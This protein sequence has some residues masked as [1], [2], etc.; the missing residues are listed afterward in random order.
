MRGA[1]RVKFSWRVM[2]VLTVMVAA[3]FSYGAY[4]VQG[5]PTEEHEVTT[6]CSYEQNIRCNY[7]AYLKP[8]ILYGDA[9]GEGETIYIKLAERIDVTF[10]YTFSCSVEGS[11]STDYE[12]R[13]FLEEPSETGWRK[14]ID[15]LV[16]VETAETANVT[17][18]TLIAKFSYNITEINELIE[19]IE[20]DIG[21][22][23]STYQIVTNVSINATDETAIETIS[24]PVKERAV[25]KLNYMG[26]Y[27]ERAGVIEIEAPEKHLPGSITENRVK[28]IESAVYLK[29]AIN[30]ALAAWIVAGCSLTAWRYRTDRTWFE[31]LPESERIM[32][33]FKVMESKGMPDMK[34]VT[35]SSI[36]DLKRLVDDYDLTMFHT[37]MTEG[38]VFFTIDNNIVYRYVART[39]GPEHPDSEKMSAAPPKGFGKA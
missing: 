30:V 15:E 13:S 11:I 19:K 22:T 18:A 2:A 12:I 21:Y 7:T 8:N 3:L 5:I 32:K 10:N 39:E 29:T 28:K 1:D 9:I 25:L 14:P 23:S 31:T 6:L 27:M 26:G 4:Y 38:D 34:A 17:S 37:K 36:E 35:L 33:R 20:E 16:S 24:K